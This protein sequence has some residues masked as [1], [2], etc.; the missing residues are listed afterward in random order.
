MAG[1]FQ[2][3]P[4]Y[5]P[6][7]DILSACAKYLSHA[8]NVVTGVARRPTEA[9]RFPLVESSGDST[10]T[11]AGWNNVTFVYRRDPARPVAEVAVIGTFRSLYVPTPLKPVLH[12]GRQTRFLSVSFRIPKRQ[13]HVYRFVIDG[14]VQNDL[15]NPQTKRQSNG[16]AWS[17]FFTEEY[18][19]PSVLREP[20]LRL[21]SRLVTEITPLRTPDAEN[22]LKRFYNDS[23]RDERAKRLPHVYRLDDAVGEVNFIDNLLAR[24]ERHRLQMYRACLRYLNDCLKSAAE[25]D[26]TPNREPS[27]LPKPYFERICEQMRQDAVPGWPVTA[28]ASARAFLLLLRRHAVIGAFSHPRYGGNSGGA[29]WEYLCQRFSASEPTGTAFDWKIAIEKPLGE[30]NVYFG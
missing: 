20:E 14:N 25:R 12:F 18:A 1:Q 7:S 28:T 8:G 22:F 6:D 30:S 19:S 10:A 24:G 17:C 23:D 16:E 4:F 15:I 5:Q 11:S 21:L 3:D 26:G 9:W 29:G 2:P 27:Q 13:M